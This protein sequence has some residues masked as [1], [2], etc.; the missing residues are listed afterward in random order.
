MK[1]YFPND[2]WEND[3]ITIP[4]PDLAYNLALMLLEAS[5]SY[6]RKNA[7]KLSECAKNRAAIILETLN[8]TN[9]FRT[10]EEIQQEVK[11]HG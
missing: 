6:K 7:L 9:Y 8:T 2:F 11:K 4:N 3:H 1:Y 5:A 10:I